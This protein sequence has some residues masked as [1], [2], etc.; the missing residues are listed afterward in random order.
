MGTAQ[1]LAMTIAATFRTEPDEN[2][3]GRYLVET[4]SE[5]VPRLRVLARLD[6]TPAVRR[7][8]FRASPNCVTCDRQLP[9]P[10]T[11]RYV[12]TADGPRLACRGDCFATAMVRHADEIRIVCAGGSTVGSRR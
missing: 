1:K 6:E 11:G 3:D 9:D 5:R 2:G 8:A 7:A 12:P 4:A 10:E